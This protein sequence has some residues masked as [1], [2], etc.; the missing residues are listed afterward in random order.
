[1]FANHLENSISKHEFW[2][3]FTLKSDTMK[4]INNEIISL[5]NKIK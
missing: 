1:M 3:F 4:I 2:M 5:Y